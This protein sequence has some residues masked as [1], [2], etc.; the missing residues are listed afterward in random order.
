MCFHDVP[1]RRNGS[2]HLRI[3]MDVDG[4][5]NTFKRNKSAR[6]G[7]RGRMGSRW[8]HRLFYDRVSELRKIAIHPVRIRQRAVAS[9]TV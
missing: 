3:A 7:S 2:D 8:R 4:R 1:G 9:K 6:I 5:W